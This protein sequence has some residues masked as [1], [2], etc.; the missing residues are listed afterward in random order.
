MVHFVYGKKN[1]PIRGVLGY[2]KVARH[3]ALEFFFI[4][5]AYYAGG[6]RS[7]DNRVR[8]QCLREKHR[9]EAWEQRILRPPTKGEERMIVGLYV[10]IIPNSCRTAPWGRLLNF[11][12]NVYSWCKIIGAHRSLALSFP[13]TQYEAYIRTCGGLVTSVLPH[14]PACTTLSLFYTRTGIIENSHYSNASR[15]Q[16]QPR[17]NNK[18]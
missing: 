4:A 17:K 13:R 5:P 1:Y 10:D 9:G 8:W 16:K 14:I 18:K 2:F 15:D 3:W 11:H 6:I 7:S 12:E